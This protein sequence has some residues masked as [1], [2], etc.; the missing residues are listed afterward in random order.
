MK[1][2]ELKQW[3]EM[4]G[5]SKIDCAKMLEITRQ[6]LATYE[7]DGAIPDIVSKKV[8]VAELEY[9][10]KDQY[11][12]LKSTLNITNKLILLANGEDFDKLF[13]GE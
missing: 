2:A 10:K 3:R 5:M 7:N 11:K 8:M 9:L 4:R 1:G 6:T 12:S 13:K